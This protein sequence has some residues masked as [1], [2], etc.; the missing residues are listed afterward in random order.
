MESEGH[1]DYSIT[2]ARKY[3]T[4]IDVEVLERMD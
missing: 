4:G 2:Y 3:G 1:Y